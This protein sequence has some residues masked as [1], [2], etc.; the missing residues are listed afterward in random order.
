MTKNSSKVAIVGAGTV[1]STI[2]F[3]LIVQGV[4]AEVMLIDVNPEKALGEVLDLQH[5]IEYLNR[6]VRVTVG[7]YE[8]CKDADIV[9]ITAAAPMNGETNRLMLLEKT[10]KIIEG[11]VPP[12]MKSGFDG[13][14]LVV[15]NPVDVISYYVYKLSG[16][17]KNQVIGTGTALETARLKQFIGQIM[18]IDP[19]SVQAYSMGEHGDS[20]MVPWSHVRAGGKSFCEVIIDNPERFKDVNLDEIV[21]KTTKAGWEVL[22]RKGNTQ[23]GIASAA[24]GIIS[25]IMRDENKMIP[26]STLLEGEY[27]EYD[28]YCGVPAILNREGVK[29]IGKFNL[30]DEEKVKFHRSISVIKEHINK[31]PL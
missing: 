28:V 15:S 6:N 19:R 12:I 25:A 1:G 7:S 16:L 9:V 18:N 30:T 13:H 14:F 31:L 2:A 4:C 17:P 11:I 10:A 29:E 26:V 3:C 5:S 24:T 21:D 23:Y 8:D 27:G 20:Q 22:S